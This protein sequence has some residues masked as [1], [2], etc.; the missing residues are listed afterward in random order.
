MTRPIAADDGLP[1]H[2]GTLH[3][4]AA[5]VAI[6]RDA[7]STV[8]LDRDAYGQLCQFMVEIFE[9]SGQITVDS[10]TTSVTELGRLAAMVS[11]SAAELGTA[12]TAARQTVTGPAIRLPL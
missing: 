7:A 1:A 2:A 4:L 11:A 8:H 6:G 3:R 10:L 9:P 12:N 5:Q